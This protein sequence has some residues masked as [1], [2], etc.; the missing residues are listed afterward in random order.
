MSSDFFRSSNHWRLI[1]KL[2]NSEVDF[3]LVDIF[4]IEQKC[5]KIEGCLEPKFQDRASLR[6][7]IFENT[8]TCLTNSLI[9]VYI[10]ENNRHTLPLFVNDK[11]FFFGDIITVE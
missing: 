3:D 2:N 8:F 1:K 9:M 4:E 11:M 7:R 6:N 5:R 10:N